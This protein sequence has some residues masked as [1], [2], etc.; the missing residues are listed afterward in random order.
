MSVNGNSSISAI[1]PKDTYEQ[2][3]ID[4]I[5][6]LLGETDEAPDGE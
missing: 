4:T 3:V 6:W 2:G 1:G 5:D